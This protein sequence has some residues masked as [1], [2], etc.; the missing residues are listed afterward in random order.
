MDLKILEKGNAAGPLDPLA[1][2]TDFNIFQ[3]QPLVERICEKISRLRN[4]QQFQ[5]SLNQVLPCASPSENKE[6]CPRFCPGDT[7]PVAV[8]G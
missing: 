1:V 4:P 5:A 3:T 2:A 6:S 7:T 8:W